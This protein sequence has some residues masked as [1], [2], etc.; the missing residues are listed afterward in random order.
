MTI[1]VTT[2]M[3]AAQHMIDAAKAKPPGALP[4]Y[5]T[6]ANGQV[7]SMVAS[8]AAVRALFE[9]ADLIHAD[10]QPMVIASRKIKGSALPERAATTDLVHDVAKL[11]AEQGASF[12]MF[13]AREDIN[14]RACEKLVQLHPGLIIAGRRNGYFSPDEETAV[15]NEINAAKPDIL[16]VSLGVPLE[17]SFIVRNLD[18]LTNVGVIKTSGGMLDFLSDKRRRAPQWMQDWSL[19]WLYRTLLEPR[20][21]GPR[22]LVTNFHAAMLLMLVL[23]FLV[24]SYHDTSNADLRQAWAE[25]GCS[26]HISPFQ[27]L[28]FVDLFIGS[29]VSARPVSVLIFQV[30]AENGRTIMILPVLRRERAGAVI[31]ESFDLELADYIMPAFTSAVK[32]TDT[33][34]REIWSLILAQ[35]PDADFIT[36]KKM[37][38]F[39]NQAANPLMSLGNARAMGISTY[40]MMVRR[41]ED[42]AAFRKTGIFHDCQKRLRKWLRQNQ[43]VTQSVAKTPEEAEHLFRELVALRQHRFASLNRNDETRDS[44]V[45]EFYLALARKG[46]TDG[47][48]CL[49]ALLV[50]G[51]ILAVNYGLLQNDRL[52]VVMIGTKTEKWASFSPGLVNFVRLA[53]WAIS[54]KLAI[55][56]LGVGELVYKK[57]FNSEPVPLYECYVAL[58]L[59]GRLFGLAQD[60]R[61]KIRIFLK[62]RPQLNLWIRKTLA[63]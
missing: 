7:L 13:G 14:H 54:E 6:S 10:G 40:P 46:V 26:G 29:V 53:E 24:L 36:F 41:A 22:Y 19:E 38:P 42:I 50:D 37:P 52:V 47:S 62:E 28:D 35:I 58:S 44:A 20:R 4:Q 5:I 17:Q 16:W 23:P 63:K 30:L 57:R 21:L 51:E 33:D 15:V 43:T 9:K 56:D 25:L 55:Y 49:F 61:R 34:M 48:V 2:R 39:W 8:N 12:F 1:A 18:R 31:I 27:T 11:A 32:L 3:A 60:A 59:R 45:F